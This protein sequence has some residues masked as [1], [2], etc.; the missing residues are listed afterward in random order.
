MKTVRQYGPAWIAAE[1]LAWV[2]FPVGL[3]WMLY[4]RASRW[5][6]R[7][8][9]QRVDRMVRWYPPDWRAR[10]GD[11]FGALLLDAARGG[12]D[13][14]RLWLDVAR[15]AAAIRLQSAF[16]PRR[17]WLA[18]ALWTAG[19]LLVLPGAIVPLLLALGDA[20]QGFPIL[21]VPAGDRWAVAIAVIA[22]GLMLMAV[23]LRIFRAAHRADRM[24]V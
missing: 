7:T 10:H 5:A 16:R 20:P 4:D 23:A 24:V 19:V 11:E 21:E 9:E 22:A 2:L 13:G 6:G 17:T 18:A 15:E 14:P 3:L 1:S 8:P 12:Q